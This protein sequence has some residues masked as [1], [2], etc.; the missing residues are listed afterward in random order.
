MTAQS[1]KTGH[2]F[3]CPPTEVVASCRCI[4]TYANG[5]KGSQDVEVRQRQRDRDRELQ[6]AVRLVTSSPVLQQK[7]WPLV[8]V[9][10]PLP[11]EPRGAKM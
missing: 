4:L 6:V 11:M 10:S 8:A 3:T 5:T 1:G 9:S 7:W 2:K